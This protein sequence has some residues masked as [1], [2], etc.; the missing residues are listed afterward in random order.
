[1]I[2]PRHGS[3]VV[4]KTAH[5]LDAVADANEGGVSLNE[6]VEKL[7]VARST[8]YRILNSLSAHNL[9]ERV[10][11]GSNYQL[12]PRFVELARRISPNADRVTLIEAARPIMQS[13]ADRIHESVKLSA[14]EGDEMLTILA[15]ASPAEYALT[16]RVG[17]RSPK[18]VGA[19]GKLALAYSSPQ[20]VNAYSSRGLVSRTPYTITDPEALVEE[21][22]RIRDDGFAEDNLES[23]LGI[24][25]L[26]API[27]D[28]SD[29]LIAAVSV[30]FIG[31][32][33]PERK[34]TIRKEVIEVADALTRLLGG[35]RPVPN[36]KLIVLY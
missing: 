13:A 29:R 5:L 9:V 22:Q 25:A 15:A 21:L 16:V 4:E 18:H 24:R 26:A 7:G 3:P 20:D 14:P 31:D 23:G 35:K 33:A 28:K 30:P 10:K 32:A 2:E 17:S 12:G 27:F 34:R 19:A 36:E 6:L 11:G 1:M 8:V